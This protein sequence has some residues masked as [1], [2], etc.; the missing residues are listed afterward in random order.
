PA[1]SDKGA[2]QQPD[3]AGAAASSAASDGAGQAD[4][5]GQSAP[6]GQTG[7]SR[8]PDTSAD[9]DITCDVGVI[10]AGRGG[11]SAACRAAVLALHVVLV[12]RYYTLGGVCLNVGCIPSKALL[13]TVGVLESAR[14]LSELGI[15]FGEP[16]VDLDAL[17]KHKDTVVGKL[18]TGLA[19]M[20]KARKVKV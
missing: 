8:Q 20:A 9:A 15:S 2:A 14:K 17:R 3:A 12:E 16:S 10:G 11:Y 6:S 19:G 7:V 13:H 5:S 4:A 1:Q 18:T